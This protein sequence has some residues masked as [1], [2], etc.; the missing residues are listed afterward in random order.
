MQW[1][2]WYYFI[3][4]KAAVQARLG[5]TNDIQVLPHVVPCGM[6]RPVLHENCPP[7]S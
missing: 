2:R 7:L 3:G 6:H 1:R 4:P 5:P